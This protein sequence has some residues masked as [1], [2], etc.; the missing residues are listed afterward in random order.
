M[1]T[2]AAAVAWVAMGHYK[3]LLRK[4]QSPFGYYHHSVLCRISWV[5]IN[6]QLDT[7]WRQPQ[8]WPQSKRLQSGITFQRHLLVWCCFLLWWVHSLCPHCKDSI[9]GRETQPS[10]SR[11]YG[12][13]WRINMNSP[14]RYVWAAPSWVISCY[15]HDLRYLSPWQ[16]ISALVIPLLVIVGW[17]YV[18]SSLSVYAWYWQF[19]VS[20]NR[21]HYTS[22]TL[23]SVKC[24]CTGVFWYRPIDHPVIRIRVSC[25]LFD[26]VSTYS[27]DV[28]C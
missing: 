28:R 3:I 11:L 5:A 20:V 9:F 6:Y 17:M 12:W 21:W 1:N 22:R 10:M 13:Q 18:V 19:L 14:S 2:V 15:T 23:R 8:S 7:S 16:Q 24:G 25:I 27:P 4:F 26:H